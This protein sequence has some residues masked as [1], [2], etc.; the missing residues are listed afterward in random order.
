MIQ[1]PAVASY[2]ENHSGA[3]ENSLMDVSC[4]TLDTLSTNNYYDTSFSVSDEAKEASA[5]VP[6][7]PS[8]LL[9]LSFEIVDP[10]LRQ[11]I[12]S[13]SRIVTDVNGT[14]TVAPTL[15][16]CIVPNIL[17]YCDAITLSRASSTCRGW[18]AIA[19]RD[20]MWENLCRNK[21]GVSAECVRPKPDPTKLLY[22]LTHRSLQEA[23]RSNINPFTG[24]ERTN[25]FHF[26]QRIPIA[27]LASM[28]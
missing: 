16:P 17:S 24:R 14:T 1:A 5:M 28:L 26:G 2:S 15:V 6:Y 13:D 25:R 27:A 9:Q 23:C 12:F 19:Q 7:N 18:H 20:D 10:T 11:L 21:F 4:I 22:I 8:P 3:D